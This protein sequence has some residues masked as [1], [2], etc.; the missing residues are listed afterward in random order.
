MAYIEV[1]CLISGVFFFEVAFSINSISIVTIIITHFNHIPLLSENISL[2][3]FFY[4]VS[5]YLFFEREH[6]HEWGRAGE[7]QRE[8][9]NFNQ[10]PCPMWLNLM[11]LGS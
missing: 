8:R 6:V 7:G 5:F 9:E 1:C 3:K 10:A 11:T 2:Y 4:L